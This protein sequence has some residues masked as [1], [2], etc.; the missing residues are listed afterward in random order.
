MT[1]IKHRAVD[2]TIVRIGKM[3]QVLI[4][5]CDDCPGAAAAEL[6]QNALGN[7]SSNLRFGAG[8]EL[9]Y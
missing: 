3:L 4:V 8:S 9:V 6:P 7:G 1:V 5:C 2:D